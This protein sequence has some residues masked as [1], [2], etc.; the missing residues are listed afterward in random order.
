VLYYTRISR[1]VSVNSKPSSGVVACRILK[2]SDH[3]T[4]S[5]GL[6]TF[7]ILY[8]TTPDDGFEVAETYRDICV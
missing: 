1:Y 2:V 5:N 6:L 7:S 8:A 3:I 4:N